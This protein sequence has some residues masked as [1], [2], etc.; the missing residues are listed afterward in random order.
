MQGY[1]AI[2]QSSSPLQGGGEEEESEDDLVVGG[3]ATGRYSLQQ[4]TK[5]S[6][7]DKKTY[8]YISLLVFLY[9][10]SFSLSIPAFPK[11][12]L[13][14]FEG[15]SADSAFY[16][17]LS[18]FVRYIV[19]FFFAPIM[20]TIADHFG[21]KYLLIMSYLVGTI[22]FMLLCAFPTLDVLFIA[23]TMSGIGDTGVAT[24]FTIF[25][26]ICFFNGD[27]LTEQFGKLSA[28]F[29][30]SF[31]IGPLLGGIICDYNLR[32]CLILS[33]TLALFTAVLCFFLLEESVGYSQFR[34][35]IVSTRQAP[36]KITLLYILKTANPVPKMIL[37]FS[38]SRMRQITFPVALLSLS[39]GIISIYYIFMDYKFHSSSTD[40]G[41]FLSAFS[42]G[43][44]CAQGILLKR[45][46]PRFWL[47]HQV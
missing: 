31:L 2:N 34:N 13:L 30:L 25:S 41:I 19:E 32:L 15:D 4:N 14:I 42:L 11:L 20:G 24:S 40:I 47:P 9:G 18:M 27:N 39:G 29:A 7:G 21:R 23:R 36:E 10:L 22:E 38:H 12:T 5:S 8:I 17:G 3:G 16:Y 6:S 37:Q 44:A 33:A 43:N 45:I 26:D 35:R 46:I 28:F 1:T